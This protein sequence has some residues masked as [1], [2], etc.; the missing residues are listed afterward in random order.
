MITAVINPASKYQHIPVFV[1]A[2]QPAMESAKV[3]SKGSAWEFINEEELASEMTTTWSDTIS[4][5]PT[6]EIGPDDF[7]RLYQWFLS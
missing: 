4:N 1:V 7:E 3:S 5:A 6:P 2:N